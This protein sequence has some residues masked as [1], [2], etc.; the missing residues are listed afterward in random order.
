[1]SKSDAGYDYN[2]YRR[3]LA[4]ADDEAKRLALVNLLI[5]EKAKDQ[6]A[7]QALRARLAGLALK[8]KPKP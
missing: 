6:L 2:R 3:L 5:E 8:E 4:E 7:T 1:M